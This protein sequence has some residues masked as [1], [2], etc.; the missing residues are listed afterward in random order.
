MSSIAVEQL[1]QDVT[2]FDPDHATPSGRIP[3]LDGLRGV[4]IGMVV[5]FHYFSLHLSTSPNTVIW[6]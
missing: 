2:A 6:Y 1:D 5:L 4:A 3:Q